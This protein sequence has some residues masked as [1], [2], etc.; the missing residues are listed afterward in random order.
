MTVITSWE[1]RLAR[2]LESAMMCLLMYP[3][4][5][6][7]WPAGAKGSGNNGHISGKNYVVP[8]QTGS[9]EVTDNWPRVARRTSCG[10]RKGGG[11]SNATRD[12]ILLTAACEVGFVTVAC[13][14]FVF[15]C[16]S[17]IHHSPDTEA[18]HPV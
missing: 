12:H 15:R 1:E 7:E 13:Y 18:S 9:E 3:I 10:E 2:V 14:L 4:V 17:S 5:P 8:S 11:E 6:S 16:I